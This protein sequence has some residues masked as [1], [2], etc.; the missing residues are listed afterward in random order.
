MK[1][2]RRNL[3]TFLFLLTL[4][5][6]F[7]GSGFSQETSR[8]GKDEVKAMLGKPD[9]VI[10]DVPTQ[11][12]WEAAHRKIEGAVREDPSR[13]TSWMDKY[14]KGRVLVFYCD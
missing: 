13:L 14:P 8:L 4:F 11:P 9:V 6:A 10:L 1:K 2:A 3:S 5:V 12:D 7:G